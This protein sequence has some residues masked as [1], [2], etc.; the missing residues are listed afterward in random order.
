MQNDIIKICNVHGPLTTKDIIFSKN[1]KYTHWRCTQCSR[2]KSLFRRIGISREEK[3]ALF[4]KQNGL[5][6]I[7]KCSFK[8]KYPD[9]PDASLYVDHC[10]D[11]MVVRG[12]L[13][14][15]CNSSIGRANHN[16]EVL[17]KYIYY[18]NS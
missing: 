13:C 15:L 6:S 2:D 9:K 11:S 4:H 17:K 7:C 3:V 12:L 5:C 10:H 8:S 1:G 16:V 14:R 18:L